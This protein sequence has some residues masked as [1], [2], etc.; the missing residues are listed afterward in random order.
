MEIQ[1]LGTLDTC[2]HFI[3]KWRTSKILAVLACVLIHGMWFWLE[4][5]PNNYWNIQS[6]LHSVKLCCVTTVFIGAK[7]GITRFSFFFKRWTWL[8][9]I[10]LFLFKFHRI[11]PVPGGSFLIKLLRPATFL[12]KRPWHNCFRVNFAKS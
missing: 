8:H 4:Y 9:R 5:F 2:Q 11:T 12:K 3:I 6:A 1:L 10:C 7:Y